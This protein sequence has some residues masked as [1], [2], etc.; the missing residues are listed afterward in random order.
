MQDSLRA[1][2][3]SLLRRR[4]KQYRSI[5][6]MILPV[7]VYF[8][9][10]SFY[11]LILGL[12]QS[13]QKERLLGTPQFIGLKNYL[14]LLTQDDIFMKYVLP[15]TIEFA[16]IVGPGGYILSFM[17]A[18]MLA[19]LPK[20][21]RTIL[22]LSLYSPSM[23]S[24]VASWPGASHLSSHRSLKSSKGFPIGATG[25]GAGGCGSGAA[26]VSLERLKNFLSIAANYLMR[27]GRS[28]RLFQL[29]HFRTGRPPPPN[30][31]RTRLTQ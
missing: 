14:T 4:L 10:F 15:N 18:W 3:R 16:V 19:Q 5:Y 2:G 9:I 13:L 20:L 30:P 26:T 12:I 17:L 28:T 8:L 1:P 24:G 6:L 22:A 11:P 7:L 31:T 23:T 29:D 21:P 25:I 27:T